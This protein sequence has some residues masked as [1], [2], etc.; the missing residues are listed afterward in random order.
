MVFFG[1][2]Q[3]LI[4][5]AP[6]DVTV[7]VVRTLDGVHALRGDYERLH[8]LTGNTLPFALHDWHIAWWTHLASTGRS[9][10]DSP[11]TLV[12]RAPNGAVVGIVPL[13]RTERF[14]GGPLKVTSLTPLGADPYITELK[15]SLIAPSWEREVADAVIAGMEKA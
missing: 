6:V 12:A 15:P 2:A 8:H 10:L 4:R 14:A 11:N 1:G 7:D 9:V 3:A 5:S 13:V